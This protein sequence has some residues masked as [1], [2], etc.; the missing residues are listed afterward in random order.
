[1]LHDLWIALKPGTPGSFPQSETMYRVVVL[2]TDPFYPAFLP[3]V[4]DWDDIMLKLYGQEWHDRRRTVDKLIIPVLRQFAATWSLPEVNPEDNTCQSQ[5][6][7][8]QMALCP[9][10]GL[11]IDPDLL[12]AYFAS[13]PAARYYLSTVI[14]GYCQ[15]DWNYLKNLQF[16]RLFHKKII[17]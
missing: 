15:Y 12:P 8:W 7:D 4:L 11:A 16:C 3:A 9:E 5:I 14:G 10:P 17:Q 1:L 6:D 2:Q 13:W